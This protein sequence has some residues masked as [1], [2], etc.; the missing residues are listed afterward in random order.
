MEVFRQHYGKP[1]S[2][3]VSAIINLYKELDM[4]KQYEDTEISFHSDLI[5]EIKKLPD[6]IIPHQLLLKLLSNLRQRLYSTSS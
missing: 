6:D 3:S 1:S 5:K 4:P 2:D